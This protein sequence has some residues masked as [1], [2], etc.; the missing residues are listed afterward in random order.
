MKK[1]K[2]KPLTKPLQ[3]TVHV[4]G[5][6]SIS[7]RALA[8]AALTEGKTILRNMLFSD[9]TKYMM[10]ALKKVGLKININKKQ[11]SVEIEGGIK[12][13][14]PVKKPLFIGNA[15]TAIRF[16][17]ALLTLTENSYC[18]T[19]NSRMQER[20][21]GDLL[22]ALN[23]LGGSTKS[24]IKKGYP[25]VIIKG[26]TLRGGEITIPG[27]TS[28]QFTSA[29]L[30]V[31]PYTKE[32]TIITIS[33]NPVSVPYLKMT[34]TM[35]K[36]FGV[37]SQTQK[38]NKKYTIKN[39][40]QYSPQDYTIESD[41]SSASYFFA[42][43]AITGGKV[44]VNNISFDS[45]QGDIQF[46]RLLEKMGC[47]VNENGNSITVQG[48]GTL[49]GIDV[50][51]SDI[52]DTAPTLAVTALFASSPTTIKGVANMR[53]KECDRIAALNT[54][55]T[56]LGAGIEEF[57][58]GLKISPSDNY[59]GTTLDTYDDHRMAMSLALAGLIIPEVIILDPDCCSKT[60][61]NFFKIFL[62]LG[63]QNA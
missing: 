6:K 23:S 55:L 12:N 3:A 61:P 28:S 60:F 45:L 16:L 4:P 49:R 30:L 40:Q 19:G 63:E 48:T 46:A 1:I 43:A 54:E 13:F 31:S 44:T 27:E 2:I 10:K 57:P 22:T 58:D 7:N 14:R 53:V 33:G 47:T 11:N 39:N 35:M 25:P 32:E 34:T 5:S 62:N 59:H 50:N 42:A 9:D 8:I 15:G 56:K 24:Q 20:P 26:Q 21:I 18:L 37:N 51:M 41:A 38:D 17:T 52:S 29:A 36:Q